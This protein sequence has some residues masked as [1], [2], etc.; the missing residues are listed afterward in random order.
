LGNGRGVPGKCRCFQAWRG[1]FQVQQCRLDRHWVSRLEREV[2]ERPVGEHLVEGE[3]RRSW[4]GCDGRFI[5]RRRVL[6]GRGSQ[7]RSIGCDWRSGCAMRR[8]GPGA[9]VEA[10]RTVDV[11]DLRAIP[12]P[13]RNVEKSDLWLVRLDGGRPIRGWDG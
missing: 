2:F 3:C 6:G 12:R 1:E 9:D 8:D 7:G 4:R 10:A 5:D 13:A 11:D